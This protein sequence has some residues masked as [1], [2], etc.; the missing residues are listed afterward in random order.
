[1]TDLEMKKKVKEVVAGEDV[2]YVI[3]YEQG[4]YGLRVSPSFAY[5]PED[6]DGFIFSPMCVPNL[7]NY[8]TL[9]RN[10]PL[11]ELEGG[12][13]GIIVKGCDS[14]TLIQIL[15]EK[16]ISREEVI[17]LGMP[18]TGVIDPKKIND[19][20]I[21]RG[22]NVKLR[23][24]GDDLIIHTD[25]GDEYT[26][27]REQALADKC[28]SCEYPN[29]LI[30]DQLL[31]K[32]V[33]GQEKENYERVKQVEN[34][35]LKERWEYWEKKFERCI[36]CYACREACPLCYCDQCMA[37]QTDPQWLPRAVGVS[38]NAAWHIMRAVHLA[39]RCG[40]CGECERAC[41]MDIPL[42]ELNKKLEMEARDLYE[43]IPGIDLEGE[44]LLGSFKVDDS[45]DFI[46]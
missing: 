41:P 40:G 30:Y 10:N 17:I 45:E 21:R 44:P 18:C 27:S 26:V 4:S 33:E 14:R 20:D 23:E 38:E 1:M 15:Q 19:L 29:P 7:V 32:E 2:K 9:E 42:M 37:T 3:G 24:D 34:M 28:K 43:Y 46:L 8:L 6:V 16:G 11:T 22:E 5:T 12:K 39:G 13:V 31:G 36:R 35:P 25:N